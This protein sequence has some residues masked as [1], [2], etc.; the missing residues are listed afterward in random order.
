[1]APLPDMKLGPD[2]ISSDL[3]QLYEISERP[4][5]LQTESK[6]SLKRLL[7]LRMEV[8]PLMARGQWYRERRYENLKR[9]LS[10]VGRNGSLT[11]LISYGTLPVR[12]GMT[13]N[14]LPCRQGYLLLE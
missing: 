14:C 1:M 3:D 2:Y 10:T 5:C 12:K 11:P 13:R 7:I 8:S 9:A 6:Q 4:E